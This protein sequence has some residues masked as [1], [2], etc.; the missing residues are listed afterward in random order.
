MIAKCWLE[1]AGLNAKKQCRVFEIT[2]D[3]SMAEQVYIRDEAKKATLSK[4]KPA[5][6]VIVSPCT[7]M[8]TGMDGLQDFASCLIKL[9]DLFTIKTAEQAIGRIHR[10][11]QKASRVYVLGMDVIRSETCQALL[12]FR[13][14]AVVICD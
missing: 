13:Q 9:G 1:R 12:S 10:W 2:S 8:S 14:R 11:V 5:N 7:L 6:V 4:A 3:I